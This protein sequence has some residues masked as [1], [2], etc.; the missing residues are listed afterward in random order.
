MGRVEKRYN[1]IRFQE[2]EKDKIFFTSDTH[3]FHENVIHYSHRPFKSI[4]EHNEALIQNWNAVVPED[5]IV[6]HLGD[7]AFAGTIKW[8]EIL[9]QLNGKIYL[10]LG[11]HDY[12]NF[13]EPVKKYFVD[14]KEQYYIAIGEQYIM[15]NHCPM[16]CYG[17]AY[18]N[19][20]QLFGHVHTEKYTPIEKQKGLDTPRLKYLFSTQYDVGVDNNDYRPIS[21]NEIREI[22]EKQK[23]NNNYKMDVEHPKK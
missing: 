11:N 20:W 23:I 3:F 1:L 10:C 14:V 7:F 12:K 4:E 15:L 16:L 8:V 18:R 13:K 17:G 5:G 9:E 22:I 19:V 21:Y 6:F 2:E